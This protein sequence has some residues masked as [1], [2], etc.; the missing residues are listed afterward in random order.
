MKHY[1][2][3]R[4]R[5]VLLIAV[6]LAVAL[7]VTSSLTDLSVPNMLVKGVLAPLRSGASQLVQQAERLYDYIFD[8]ESISTENEDLKEQIA[9]LEEDARQVDAVLRENERLRAL[10]E[11]T[12]THEDFVLVDGY[13]ISWSSTEWSSTFTINRGSNAGIEEGMCAITANGELVGLVSEVGSN[14]SVI[15]TVL[16]SSLEIHAR[17]AS[18]AAGY[19]GM[20]RGGYST[21]VK[22]KLRMDYL[23]SSAVIR[24]KDQVVT[25]GSTVYPRDLVVGHVEKVGVDVTGVAKY[26]ILEPAADMG[27]LEQVFII[28][29]YD[30]G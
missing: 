15:K 5:V 21:G 14:Y 1:F 22:D 17:I 20:V 7:G 27:S 2:S 13:V 25:A 6:L 26:A 10:L 8:Y 23:S 19:K 11:L 28:T 30:A 3:T 12:K 4:V 18:S 16:D 29:E 24:K 9:Q